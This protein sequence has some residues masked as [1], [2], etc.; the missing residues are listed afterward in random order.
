MEASQIVLGLLLV[1][2]LFAR[3]LQLR[4][5][6]LTFYGVDAFKLT[7]Y[8]QNN[9]EFNIITIYSKNSYHERSGSLARSGLL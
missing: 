6:R 4:L 3:V 2:D 7:L 1:V 5:N 9:V 8:F